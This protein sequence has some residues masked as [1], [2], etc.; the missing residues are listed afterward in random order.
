MACVRA[1]GCVPC[2]IPAEKACRDALYGTECPS[3][4]KWYTEQL[5]FFMI[6]SG[7]TPIRY[8]V[9]VVYGIGIVWRLDWADETGIVYYRYTEHGATHALCRTDAR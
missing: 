9:F 8:F 6:Q 1:V 2:S 4:L 5:A 3:E 7:N